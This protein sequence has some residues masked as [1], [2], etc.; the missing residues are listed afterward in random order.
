MKKLFALLLIISSIAFLAFPDQYRITDVEYTTVGAGFNFL[1][2][3]KPS[4]IRQKF[5]ID[6]KKIFDSEES[7]E[8]Y[9]QNY[10]KELE[11]S[12]NFE[13]VEIEYNTSFNDSSDINDVI[14]SINIIDS[15][16]LVVAPYPKYKTGEGASLKLKAKDTNFLGSL[17]TMNTS[18]SLKYDEAKKDVIPSI[19]FDFDYPFEIGNINA[20]F[21][22][23]YGLSYVVSEDETKSGLEW[24][25][26]TGISF[27]IPFDRLPLYFGIYQYT[28]GDLDY[29]YYE[30]D[31]SSY[32][33][34]DNEDYY[35]FNETFSVGTSFKLKEF[36]N[37]TS[38]SYSP[39]VSITWNWDFDGINKENGDLSSPT[40][41]F[42]HS[43]SNSKITWN[44]KMRK[45]Y[46]VS[47]SNSFSYNFQREDLYPSLTLSAQFFWNYK[48]NDQD[49][50]N[51]YGLCSNFYAF[52]YF[53]VP[54]NK[55]TKRS[56][57]SFY[58]ALRGLLSKN[59][60]YY[61]MGFYLNFDLPHNV[62]TSEFDTQI[63]NFNLQI[64]PFFDM[65]LAYDKNCGRKFNLYDDGYYCAGIEFLVY[66]LKWSSIT[67]R[68]SLG[69]DLKGA[70]KDANFLEAISNNKEIFIGIGLHY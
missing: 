58:D 22:N 54:T 24:N 56:S 63:F 70:A 5:P 47:L 31:A 69:V 67:A 42:S 39:S 59:T 38:L 25:T 52:Y 9:I 35:Y 16:H 26:K 60:K 33:Y 18:L 51:R 44:D 49:Y 30:N 65:A 11:S 36:S 41:T 14:L 8:N 48:A 46:S 55:H 64:A 45:G 29:R 13:T 57:T 32:K 61:P 68:A 21:I 15:H 40:L 12:R 34:K 37:Y 53:E 43:L 66:P 17:N 6:K 19:S 10:K 1:G 62:F 4:S 2:K 28:Y 7:L 3:T 23:D 27:S 20:T 50:W